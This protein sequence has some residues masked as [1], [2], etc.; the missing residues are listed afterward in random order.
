MS[1]FYRPLRTELSQNPQNLRD[2]FQAVNKAK[3]KAD[4]CFLDALLG[5]PPI[6]KQEFLD[7]RVR[8]HSG[9]ETWDYI[10]EGTSYSVIKKIL[11]TVKPTE[12]DTVI[13]IGSGYGRFC[14]YGALTTNA[15]Y[16][17]IETIPDRAKR[18]Q[19]SKN[20][21][22]IPNVSF[23]NTDAKDYNLSDGTIFFMFN[24]FWPEGLNNQAV[25][26][27]QLTELAR[28][29]PIT[30]VTLSMS[31]FPLMPQ[32]SLEKV[33]HFDTHLSGLDIFKSK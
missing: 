5:I 22:N 30:V 11:K 24:S 29:K 18:A 9:L 32:T 15:S 16:I 7:T 23:I 6:R 21:L 33:A 3:G 4:T 31:R 10:Y 12:N 1:E 17:G 20:E 2:M 14:L 28:Q 19:N 26:E 8:Q 13:D 25:V 27:K